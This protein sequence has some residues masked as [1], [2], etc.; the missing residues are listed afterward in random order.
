MHLLR[1]MLRIILQI[2]V[3]CLFFTV[4]GAPVVLSS[5]SLAQSQI[6]SGDQTTPRTNILHGPPKEVICDTCGRYGYS[7]ISPRANFDP[8]N[9]SPAALDLYGFPPRP[10]PHQAPQAY[11]IWK[12]VVTA[13]VTRITP[14][15]VPTKMHSGPARISS[16]SRPT[17][18]G[19][20]S[21]TSTNWSGYAINDT[22]NP[23][24][25]TNTTIFARYVVPFVQQPYGTCS[26][27]NYW[28]FMWVGIDGWGTP[29][30]L[31]AGVGA[32]TN[33]SSGLS[34]KSYF[35]WYEWYPAYAIEIS[36]FPIS[37]GDLVY[38]Y[39][40]T[41]STTQGHTYIVDYTDNKAVSVDFG[42]PTGTQ[43]AGNSLEWIVEAPTVG[44]TQALLANYVAQGWYNAYATVPSGS[45]TKTYTPGLNPTGYI[46][47]ITLQE[48]STDASY[49]YTTSNN[50]LTYG[51]SHL[52]G[53]GLWFFTEGP[54]R[55]I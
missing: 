9:A 33:C 10:D 39:V 46:Y 48:N 6:L 19:P 15:L 27:T 8:L 3:V 37:P 51:S 35:A 16:V 11:A 29:D 1:S 52:L 24:K 42:A 38:V 21:V 18:N 2:S 45:S 41:T 32:A 31:Q 34:V 36:N 30:V 13:N 44:G 50:D 12:E 22:N 14:V 55:H 4:F 17:Q 7:P 54:A 20:T 47:N 25:A 5:G 49:A 26:Q 43:L 40:W 28:D 53:T 23:F